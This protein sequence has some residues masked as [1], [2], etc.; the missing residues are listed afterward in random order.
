VADS[1]EKLIFPA[2]AILLAMRLKPE[3]LWRNIVTSRHRATPFVPQA[4]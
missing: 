2:P 3:R 4:V 1:V